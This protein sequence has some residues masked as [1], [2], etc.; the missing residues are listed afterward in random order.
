MGLLTKTQAQYYSSAK[1]FTGDGT[2]V[3]FTLSSIQ[4]VFSNNSRATIYI[5]GN[6]ILPSTYTF[7][8][9]VTDY[10]HV[11]FSIASQT[12]Y[13]PYN[14]PADGANIQVNVADEIGSGEYHHHDKNFGSY[15]Y[16]PLDD[17]ISGFMIAYV[18]EDKIISKVRRADVV[19]HAKRALQ[20][21]S[22]DT[23]R[24]I[25]T[26]EIEVPA[27]LKMILPQD[28]VGYV[29]LTWK[30]SS[31]IEHIIYPAK[32]T[33]NP[34]AIKQNS[35]GSYNFDTNDDNIDDTTL[36]IHPEDS[37]TW[38]SYK[39]ATPSEN[40]QDYEDD[41]YWPASGGRYGLDPQHSQTNGSYFIDQL[42]GYIH[43]SSNISGK[44]VILKY[45]SDGLGQL[46]GCVETSWNTAGGNG[47]G[48][49]GEPNPC[50]ATEISPFYTDP[51]FCI[52]CFAAHQPF[53]YGHPDCVCCENAP[54]RG[55][56][57]GIN[58]QCLTAWDQ[59]NPVIHKF[60]EEAIYKHIAY[61]VLSSK[62]NISEY[63]VSRYKKERFAEIRK[64]K[65]RL[66]NIKLEEIAQTLKGRSKQIK[67]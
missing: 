27:S 40:Q 56:G 66:S 22:Y 2:T 6:L 61:A 8:Y 18:G 34:R 12:S 52:D 46:N 28:Y 33:S 37:D 48:G 9:N 1:S 45:I 20:E 51:K 63:I 44:T 36:L 25:K 65:L 16:V 62:R 26:Q 47:G 7:S 11:D 54:P 5:D 57:G 30:D 21:L 43:F 17:V 59:D 32:K 50:L 3:K 19:F 41:Y 39:N 55:G 23:L 49:N 60:A 67:H 4:S 13:D 64:A 29:K 38:E 15:Q 24:S 31:G 10:W 14:A 42:K 53:Y 35:D 58:Q